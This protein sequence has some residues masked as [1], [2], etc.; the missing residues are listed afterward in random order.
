MQINCCFFASI[1]N[2]LAGVFTNLQP[3][4]N[5]IFSKT[6]DLHPFGKG[7]YTIRIRS[8]AG[9]AARKIMAQ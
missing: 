2:Q 7:V 8:N 5:G 4:I 3:M 9:G 6:I 1:Q